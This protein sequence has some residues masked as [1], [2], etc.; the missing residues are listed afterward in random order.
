VREQ[1]GSVAARKLKI[2]LGA[3]VSW[4]R[5]ERK[6]GRACGHAGLEAWGV[7]RVRFLGR[8]PRKSVEGALRLKRGEDDRAWS[9]CSGL[10]LWID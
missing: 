10:S 8:A 1:R 6:C 4:L 5:L 3:Q 2:G 9:P 7:V